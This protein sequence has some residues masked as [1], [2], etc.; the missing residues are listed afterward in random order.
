[1]TTNGNDELSQ[2]LQGYVEELRDAKRK[3]KTLEEEISNLKVKAKE[4]EE[5]KIPDVMLEHG[6]N[7]VT[8]FSGARVEV[9]PYYFAR[10]PKDNPAPFYVWLEE[11][12]HGS[13]VKSHFEI[14]TTDHNIVDIFKSTAEEVNQPF[15]LG[16]GVHWKTLEAWFKEQC[17]RGV[18]LP[19]QLF[20]NYVGRK[21]VV[22]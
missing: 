14:W 22:K 11:H 2:E 19:T 16:R 1:M 18:S 7:A 13:L 17:E 6:L 3:I 8:L 10:V 5:V 12:G 4:V 20:E 15:D 9:K 21:A